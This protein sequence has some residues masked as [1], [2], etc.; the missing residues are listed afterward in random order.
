M[1]QSLMA[2]TVALVLLLL[3][4]CG[5]DDKPAATPVG[6]PVFIS[7]TNQISNPTPAAGTP[8]PGAT[9][10]PQRTPTSSPGVVIGPVVELTALT[11]A[12]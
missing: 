7:A 10:A 5:G 6:T 3:V 4:A 11:S 9:S 1:T 2:I 8:M 12:L